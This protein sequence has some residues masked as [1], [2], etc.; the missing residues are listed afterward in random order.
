MRIWCV[1]FLSK[2]G[3]GANVLSRPGLKLASA[4]LLQSRIKRIGIRQ[5]INAQ[6]VTYK[7]TAR[8]LDPLSAMHT[9]FL[10]G[11]CNVLRLLSINLDI[12]VAAI[13][14][15]NLLRTTRLGR[16]RIIDPAAIRVRLVHMA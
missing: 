13:I 10:R 7:G 16:T 12:I 14:P 8:R 2:E 11:I 1:D 15:L 9:Y 6:V 3:A 4:V 5:A